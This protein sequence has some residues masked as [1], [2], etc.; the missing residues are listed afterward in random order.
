MSGKEIGEREVGAEC[1]NQI[2]KD[3]RVAK[4]GQKR[5]SGLRVDHPPS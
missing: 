4:A 1:K 2:N 3:S 5:S